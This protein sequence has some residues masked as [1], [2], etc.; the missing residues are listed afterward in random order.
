[1]FVKCEKAP[2][3]GGKG[4]FM[5]V[6]E[7]IKIFDELMSNSFTTDDKR[8]WLSSIDGQIF[9]EI[10]NKHEN[11]AIESFSPYNEGDMEKELLVDFPYDEDIYINF[12]E[13][14]AAKEN[15]EIDKFNQAITLFNSAYMSFQNYYNSRHM[16]KSKGGFRF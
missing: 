14:R 4:K 15:F 8:R 6:K 7:A 13:A 1:L 3:G 9:E 5:K 11:A 10:I 12:L 16:P 2:K